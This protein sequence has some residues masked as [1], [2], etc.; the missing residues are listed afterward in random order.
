[1]NNHSNNLLA[2]PVRATAVENERERRILRQE[3]LRL[4]IDREIRRQAMRG[5]PR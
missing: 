2:E 4:I 1:M 3:L 5:G